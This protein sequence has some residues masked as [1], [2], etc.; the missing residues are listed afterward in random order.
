MHLINYVFT[1]SVTDVLTDRAQLDRMLT[2]DR[3]ELVS[4]RKRLERYTQLMGQ[5][6]SVTHRICCFT[7]FRRSLFVVGAPAHTAKELQSRTR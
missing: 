6:V 7:A 3:N 1:C 4:G 5:K 2:A